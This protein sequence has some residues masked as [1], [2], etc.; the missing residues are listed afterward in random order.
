MKKL[1]PFFLICVLVLPFVSAGMLDFLVEQKV[2]MIPFYPKEAVFDSIDV[3]SLNAGDL[4]VGDFNAWGDI[5]FFSSVGIDGDL[6][7]DGNIFFRGDIN[8]TGDFDVNGVILGND[9]NFVNIG[10]TEGIYANRFYGTG[11]FN[12]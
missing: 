8:V 5:N 9:S 10:V 4:N 7:V 12:I 1:I 2:I 6:Y 11:D 3:T